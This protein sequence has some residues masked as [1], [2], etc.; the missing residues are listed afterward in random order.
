[1]IESM[2]ESILK[3]FKNYVLEHGKQPE[4]IHAFCKKNK[5]K[6]KDFFDHFPNFEAVSA[7][8]VS[9]WLESCI[10]N[11]K[12]QPEFEGYGA[13]EKVLLLFYS[14]VETMKEHRSYLLVSFKNTSFDKFKTMPKVIKNTRIPF[15][16][17]IDDIL[18]EGISVGEIPER[19]LINKTYREGLWLNFL[20]ITHFWLRDES[21]EFANTDEAIEKSVNLSM[22]MISKNGLDSI[23]EFGKFMFT[24]GF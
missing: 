20:F 4:S 18:G 17:F 2:K 1:M 12:I 6:E 21:K 15:L 11:V 23:F 7:T 19:K 10:E 14:W 8:L 13:R 16:Q 5:I 22:D 24:K 9:S 3:A